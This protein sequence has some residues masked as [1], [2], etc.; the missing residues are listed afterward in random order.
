LGCLPPFVALFQ[1]AFESFLPSYP[2]LA[3]AV[4]GA[5][6]LVLDQTRL[7]AYI[8]TAPRVDFLSMNREGIASFAGYLAIFLAGQGAGMFC[9]P[10]EKPSMFAEAGWMEKGVTVS[11]VWKEFRQSIAG[12]LAIHTIIYAGLFVLMTSYEGFNL[13]VSRRLANLPYVLGVAA[14]NSGQ[15]LICVLIE[16]LLFPN[17]YAIPPGSK[18]S[19]SSRPKTVAEETKALKRATSTLLMAFNSN[20]LFIFLVA[21]LLTGLVNMTLPTLDVSVFGA[22]PLLMLYIGALSGLALLLQMYDIKIKI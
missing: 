22:V 1:S 14:F 10:R 9:L 21:N 16:T 18:V 4:A 7:T 15:L 19:L 8:I 3:L 13:R 2:V 17:I 20:G 6:E 12:G 11:K 5:Y